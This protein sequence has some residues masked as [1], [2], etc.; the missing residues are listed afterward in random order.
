M[1]EK[2]PTIRRRKTPGPQSVTESWSEFTTQHGRQD[3]YSIGKVDFSGTQVTESEGHQWPPPSRGKLTDR[4]GSFYTSKSYIAVPRT[5]PYTKFIYNLSPVQF[6]TVRGQLLPT[7]PGWATY[8]LTVP[9][10][11]LNP[12]PWPPT[13]E[14]SDS[15]LDALGAVAVS[16]CKPTQTPEQLG[17]ALVD[18]YHDGLPAA[19][20]SQFWKN[21]TKSLLKSSAEEYLNVQFGIVP[22]LSDIRQTATQIEHSNALLSQFEKDAGQVVRRG[23]DFPSTEKTEQITNFVPSGLFVG[24]EFSIIDGLFD[25]TTVCFRNTKQRQWFRGAF[26][27]HLPTGYDSRNGLV[28]LASKANVLL[29]TDVLSPSVLWQAEPWSWAIDWFSNMGDVI[30]NLQDYFTDG[31]VMPYG[32]LMEETIVTDTYTLEPNPGVTPFPANVAKIVLVTH[33]KKRRQANPFGF[34][35]TWDGLSPFQLSILSALG[36]THLL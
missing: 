32:Y 16:R 36:I 10:P 15:T 30:S 27:Y 3:N 2:P 35:L 28:S 14:S 12:V 29:A 23:Y 18:T 7:L 5:L 11:P 19:V 4:G 26:T 21:R 25:G 22:L 9:N 20:G 6:L 1:P 8:D 34:G 33:T 17:A 24:Q 31:L 13:M